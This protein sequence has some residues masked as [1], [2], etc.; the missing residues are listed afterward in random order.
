MILQIFSQLSII[1]IGRD[2]KCKVD[3]VIFLRNNE[4]SNHSS[5]PNVVRCT[6][7]QSCLTPHLLG[8]KPLWLVL[9]INANRKSDHLKYFIVFN[10]ALCTT[11][12]LAML[13]HKMI[14]RR[15]LQ[16]VRCQPELRWRWELQENTRAS[17]EGEGGKEKRKLVKRKRQGAGLCM[18]RETCTPM[19][20][21][22]CWLVILNFR[23]YDVSET[24]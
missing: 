4:S 24:S 13:G 7:I 10:S 1:S 21:V 14:G 20:R 6:E 3:A 11:D 15:L 12:L 19:V 5:Y 22:Y 23:F 18:S 9:E 16:G 17:G 8:S 2:L